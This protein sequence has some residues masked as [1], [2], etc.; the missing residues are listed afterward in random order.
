M[1]LFFFMQRVVIPLSAVRQRTTDMPPIELL[2]QLLSHT[3]FVGLTIALLARRSARP[4]QTS[5]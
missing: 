5:S 3:V 2:D 4:G 1:G